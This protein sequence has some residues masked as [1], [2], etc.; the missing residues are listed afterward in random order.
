MNLNQE[1]A[2]KACCADLYQSQMARMVLGDN[3]H[4]GGLALTNRLAKLMGI[5]RGDWVADLASARGKGALAVARAFHCQVIGVEFGG[6]AVREAVGAVLGSPTSPSAYFVRGDAENPPLR[7]GAF[8]GVFCECSMS[9]FP[10]KAKAVAQT[11]ALLRQG[12]KFGLSDV[13]VS[14]DCLPEE[15]TGA[16][17][18]LLCLTDA[19]DVDGYAGL[20]ADGGLTLLHQVDASSEIIKILDEIESKLGAWAAWQQMSK[21]QAPPPEMLER[22]PHLLAGLR[23]LVAQGKLGYWLFVAEKAN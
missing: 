4:P 5:R 23:D 9:L 7:L 21:P 11:K 14:A 2:A 8:D 10:N 16:V 12:G 19:L 20:L 17:G 22:A 1:A 13:T 15:L 3:L 6:E 18:Q